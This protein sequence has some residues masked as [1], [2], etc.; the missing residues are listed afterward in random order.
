MR[1]SLL[2]VL[3]IIFVAPILGG[4]APYWTGYGNYGYG[5]YYDPDCY[6][7]GYS[8]YEGYY[9]PYYAYPA[10]GGSLPSILWDWG[11]QGSPLNRSAG[12]GNTTLPKFIFNI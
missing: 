4:C 11:I 2:V 3:I 9:G 12:S 7:P 8:G 10:Y 5:N 1:K 6:D